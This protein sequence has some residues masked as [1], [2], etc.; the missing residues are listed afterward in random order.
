M[1]RC[2][3]AR[4]C[5]T[6]IS[7]YTFVNINCVFL[8]KCSR[9]FSMILNRQ[10]KVLE[11]AQIVFL[12]YFW[13]WTIDLP[14]GLKVKLKMKVFILFVTWLLTSSNHNSLTEY[15]PTTTYLLFSGLG[16]FFLA[17]YKSTKGFGERLAGNLC[18][19]QSSHNNHHMSFA[20]QT[21]DKHGLLFWS[22]DAV[23]N[24]ANQKWWQNFVYDI[25]SIS[26]KV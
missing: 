18:W 19:S 3:A 11:R 22:L 1:E 5:L 24:L 16:V 17:L 23:T 25:S 2:Q 13:E 4:S 21:H 8:S 10:W 20:W 14:A 12:W 9:L 26:G 15:D 7:L 6:F